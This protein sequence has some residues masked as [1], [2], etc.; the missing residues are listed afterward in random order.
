MRS[1]DSPGNVI[2]FDI[3]PADF[4]LYP[5]GDLNV[6]IGNF[7]GITTGPVD[8]SD[9][10]LVVA[11]HGVF[12]RDVT[13]ADAVESGSPVFLKA[14]GSLTT[15]QNSNPFGLTIDAIAAGATAEVRVKLIG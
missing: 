3:P 4:D 1:Y 13:S 11:V 7:V 9:G 15:T 14:D 10:K 2:T 12:N 8:R 5:A 6:K